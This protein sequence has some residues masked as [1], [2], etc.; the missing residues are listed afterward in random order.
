MIIGRMSSK[1]AVS[2]GMQK[3]MGHI[4]KDITRWSCSKSI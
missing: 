3:I 1:Y 4:I 2:M